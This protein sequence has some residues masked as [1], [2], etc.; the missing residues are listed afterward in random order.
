MIPNAFKQCTI[1]LLII[2]SAS[3][4]PEKPGPFGQDSFLES[5][6]E[7]LSDP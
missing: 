1:T 6:K 7:K 2:Q 5:L 3:F 4:C